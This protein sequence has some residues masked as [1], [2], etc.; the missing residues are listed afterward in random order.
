MKRAYING[1]RF[2][3]LMIGAGLTG[4]IFSAIASEWI[5]VIGGAFFLGAMYAL[6][7]NGLARVFGEMPL[8]ATL[9]WLAAFSFYSAINFYPNHQFLVFVALALFLIS[10]LFAFQRAVRS[11][12]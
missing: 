9:V 1:A 7:R 6:K 8:P 3:A 10:I 11:P 12:L 4:L 2:G 5:G